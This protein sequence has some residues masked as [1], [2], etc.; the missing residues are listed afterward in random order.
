MNN[1]DQPADILSIF[2]HECIP[3]SAYELFKTVITVGIC[4]GVEALTLFQYHLIPSL[5][6]KRQEEDKY[7]AKR[8]FKDRYG[9]IYAVNDG[10]H[11][12]PRENG[13]DLLQ[14]Y[15]YENCFTYSFYAPD[16]SKVNEAVFIPSEQ[17]NCWALATGTWERNLDTGAPATYTQEQND[18]PISQDFLQAI[19]EIIKEASAKAMYETIRLAHSQV[20]PEEKEEEKPSEPQLDLASLTYPLN[21]KEAMA[22]LCSEPKDKVIVSKV[23]GV[24]YGFTSAHQ[25][26]AIDSA[27]HE[28]ESGEMGIEDNEIAG[29]W[30]LLPH[31]T[32]MVYAVTGK[33]K[34]GY[35]ED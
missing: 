20:K 25:F 8:V 31:K 5:I 34:P 29:R 13:Y 9:N 30:E 15:L 24:A 6:F 14:Q 2:K 32:F 35:E 26:Y 4:T 16:T 1:T 27:G 23:S 28:Y 22:T 12:G 7:I 18:A 3:V 11:S 21:F 19:L 33:I 10:D 17:S